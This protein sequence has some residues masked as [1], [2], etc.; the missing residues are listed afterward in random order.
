[1]TDVQIRAEERG[2]VLT[3][4]AAGI[5]ARARDRELAAALSE[6]DDL[7][8]VVATHY[9]IEAKALRALAIKLERERVGTPSK[10]GHIAAWRAA[11]GLCAHPDCRR[12]SADPALDELIRRLV[13]LLPRR[14]STHAAE[15]IRDLILDAWA[16]GQGV[17]RVCPDTPAP[18]AAREAG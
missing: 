9:R 7:P 16:L 8:D 6:D 15:G 13:D 1:V 4:I 5:L 17:A 10:C 12:A 3:E 14:M 2:R 11:E 18:A